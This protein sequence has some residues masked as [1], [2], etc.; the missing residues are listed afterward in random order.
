MKLSNRRHNTQS[1]KSTGHRKGR[2]VYGRPDMN[3][4]LFTKVTTLMQKTMDDDDDDGYD[5]YD[6]DTAKFHQ[7]FTG[8]DTC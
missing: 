4:G 8:P 1:R 7:S 2:S 5:Y 3:A 6:K